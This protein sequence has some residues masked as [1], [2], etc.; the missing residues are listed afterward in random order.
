[1]GPVTWPSEKW[2]ELWKVFFKPDSGRHDVFGVAW[3]LDPNLPKVR[4][5]LTSWPSMHA[6]LGLLH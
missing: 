3:P 4:A 2:T 6:E 5:W 1:M